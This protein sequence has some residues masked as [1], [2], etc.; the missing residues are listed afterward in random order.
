MLSNK[1]EWIIDLQ[2]DKPGRHVTLK[3]HDIELLILFYE[4]SGHAIMSHVYHY[5]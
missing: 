4:P 1:L 2:V 3:Q 5:I